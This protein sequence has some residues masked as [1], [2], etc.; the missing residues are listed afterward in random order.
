MGKPEG[1]QSRHD[2]PELAREIEVRQVEVGKRALEHNHPQSLSQSPSGQE[3]PE[4]PERHP[5]RRH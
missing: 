1:P 4:E 2:V 5:H 3:G